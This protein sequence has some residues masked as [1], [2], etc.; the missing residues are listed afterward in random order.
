MKNEDLINELDL[1]LMNEGDFIRRYFYPYVKSVLVKRPYN[2]SKAIK[3][4]SRVI[5]EYK[6]TA[7]NNKGSIFYRMIIP[8][9]WK[10]EREAVADLMLNYAI[11]ETELNGFLFPEPFKVNK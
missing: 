4:L 5:L 3:G 11:E 10:Q 9:R 1:C 7:S 2:H 8:R 6:K